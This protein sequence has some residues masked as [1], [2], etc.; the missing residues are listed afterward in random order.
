MQMS[1][2]LTAPGQK[3]VPS[4]LKESPLIMHMCP[5]PGSWNLLGTSP[6]TSWCT[7][8]GAAVP[9]LQPPVLLPAPGRLRELHPASLVSAAR[10][11][12]GN[13]RHRQGSSCHRLETASAPVL[14]SVP[15]SFVT[16]TSV[17]MYYFASEA[18]HKDPE[19]G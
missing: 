6:R 17:A 8:P 9:S 15:C 12:P 13:R 11:L 1:M 5:R 10:L 2:C 14:L 16:L 3:E 19:E 18:F 7:K 4:G